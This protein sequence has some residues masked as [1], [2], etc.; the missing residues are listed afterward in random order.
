LKTEKTV[1]LPVEVEYRDANNNLYKDTYDLKLKILSAE[2]LGK[3]G[4]DNTG[5]IIG[6]VIVLLVAGF[7]IFRK[8]SAKKK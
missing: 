5:I 8:I 2:K 3:S 7:I 1:G 4:G 6:G